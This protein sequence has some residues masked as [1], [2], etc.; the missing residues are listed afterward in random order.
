MA[1]LGDRL[2]LWFRVHEDLL[3]TLTEVPQFSTTSK[4]TDVFSLSFLNFLF[5]NKQNFE[6]LLTHALEGTEAYSEF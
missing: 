3:A 6:K 2:K 4:N 1:H 5:P